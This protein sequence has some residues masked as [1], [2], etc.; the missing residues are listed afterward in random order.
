[1]EPEL[2]S[3]EPYL[4]DL[5]A[6]VRRTAV[7]VL[8]EAA[9]AGAGP[10][11]AGAPADP[12]AGVRSAAATSLRELVETLPP[13]PALG[14]ALVDALGV[15]DSLVRTAALDVLRVLLLGDAGL[16]AAPGRGRRGRAGRAGLA[17]ACGCRQGAGC[18]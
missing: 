8:T 15:A 6:S 5:D 17:G 12:D 2:A 3:L 18:R 13:E 10:A 14:D 1:M 4:T 16:F 11:L 9:P 7:S